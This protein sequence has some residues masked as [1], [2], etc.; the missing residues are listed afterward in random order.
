M[1]HFFFWNIATPQKKDIFAKMLHL[2]RN[3]VL[4]SPSV[5]PQEEIET[6]KVG[7]DTHRFFVDM[8]Y[9]LVMSK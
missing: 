6:V 8:I 2:Q 3:L 7:G 4:L 5:F 1:S 9:P